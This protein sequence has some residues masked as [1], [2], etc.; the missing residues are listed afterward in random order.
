MARLRWKATARARAAVAAGLFVAAAGQLA[1]AA[2][3]EFRRPRLGDAEY[4]IKLERLHGLKAAQGPRPLVV[5]IGSSRVEMGVRPDFIPGGL[6]P[7][8]PA[9]FNMGITGSLQL[10][11]QLTLRRLV[12]HGYRPDEVFLEVM[13]YLL[14]ATHGR[15]HDTEDDLVRYRLRLEDLPLLGGH[16]VDALPA[17]LKSFRWVLLPWY[18]RRF[19][20][21]NRYAPEWVEPLKRS[22]GDYAFWEQTIGPL[23]WAGWGEPVVP[24]PVRRLRAEHVRQLVGAPFG[25]DP[26]SAHADR[27]LRQSLEFCRRQGIRVSLLVMPESSDV[28]GWFS[29]QTHRMVND[30]LAGLSRAY[31]AEVVDARDWLPDDHFADEQHLLVNGANVFSIH[32]GRRVLHRH[33]PQQYAGNQDIPAV[34][35][36]Q[37]ARNR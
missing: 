27:T 21:L 14:I 19:Q 2:H 18:E 5:F 36:A 23:G 20:L 3:I 16:A 24:E 11:N 30:Y 9:V 13:P 28:R 25:P 7:Q 12:R 4:A 35:E 26:I 1:L 29:P 37:A 32:L 10:Q 17:H 15:D 22:A 8:A 31:G 34:V 33:F 6:A